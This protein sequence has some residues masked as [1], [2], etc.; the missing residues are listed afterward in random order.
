MSIIGRPPVNAPYKVRQQPG[1]GNSNV[2]FDARWDVNVA[3][4]NSWVGITARCN[5]PIPDGD[6]IVQI[7]YVFGSTKT[8]FGE[9]IKVKVQ[10]QEIKSGWTTKPFKPGNFEAGEY[11]FKVSVGGYIGETIK[12]LILRDTLARRNED[13]F[14]IGGAKKPKLVF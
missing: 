14:E 12:P 8:L 6:G 3:A 2:G 4:P 7:L 5:N 11:H 13:S 1:Q 10:N 9:P